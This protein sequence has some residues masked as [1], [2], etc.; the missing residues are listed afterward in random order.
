MGASFGVELKKMYKR[1]TT[2][3][4]TSIFLVLMILWTYALTYAFLGPEGNPSPGDRQL[5]STL[6][7]RNFVSSMLGLFGGFGATLALVLGA[8]SVGSEYGWQTVKLVLTQ[9]PGRSALFA[10]KFLAVGAILA[11]TT[12]FSFAVAAISSC[13][14]TSLRNGPTD[15][16]GLPVIIEGLGAGILILA[17]FAAFG[18]FLAT[19]LRGTALALTIGLIYLLAL[20]NLLL[21]F[22]FRSEFV[23]DIGRVLPVGNAGDLAGSFGGA[24][25]AAGNASSAT[26]Q[27]ADPIQAV[28]IL[29]AWIVAFLVLSLLLFQ[30]RDVA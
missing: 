14:L 6:Y 12:L 19:L 24:P 18:M 11:A 5:L 15:F 20:E 27:T 10:G 4:V 21:L 7:P 1:P 28:L 29:L 23:A 8:L 26:P 9:R 25:P 16:P 2:W 3:V 13:A 22:S 17:T 30:K